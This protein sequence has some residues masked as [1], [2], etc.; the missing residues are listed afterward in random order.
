MNQNVHLVLSGR[1]LIS[2]NGSAA[3]EEQGISVA[4]A[5]DMIDN[6]R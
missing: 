2:M 3:Q 5:G 6:I 4:I 1:W